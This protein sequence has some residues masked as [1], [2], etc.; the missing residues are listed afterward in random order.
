MHDRSHLGMQ[1][2]AKAAISDASREGWFNDYDWV[3]LV[4]S[5]VIIRNDTF[6]LDIMQNDP[7]ATT[8]ILVNCNGN[9]TSPKVH[10]DFFA[11]K[12]GGHKICF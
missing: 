10:T 1:E 7:N 12:P 2:G 8:A 3:I 11:I 5:D 6:M 4:N 9:N